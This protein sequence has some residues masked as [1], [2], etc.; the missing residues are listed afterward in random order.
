MATMTGDA[1]G[2]WEP[3]ITQPI[4]TA[5]RVMSTGRLIPTRSMPLFNGANF[6]HFLIER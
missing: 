5:Q 6:Q 4:S 1:A 3:T 2:N